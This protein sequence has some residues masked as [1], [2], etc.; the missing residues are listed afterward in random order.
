MLEPQKIPAWT[1]T[2]HGTVL[3]L[4]R[5]LWSTKSMLFNELGLSAELLRAIDKKGYLQI[6]VAVTRR[7]I[8][9][10]LPDRNRESVNVVPLRARME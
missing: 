1:E 5:R 4:V 9:C 6:R 8:A 10:S 3:H 7:D 2:T